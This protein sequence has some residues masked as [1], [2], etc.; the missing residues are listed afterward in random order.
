M[1]ETPNSSSERESAE[2]PVSYA[3]VPLKDRP[4]EERPREKLLSRGSGVLSDAELIA[5]LFGSGTRVD[6]RSLSAV[7]LGQ[8]LLKR[9]GSL[10]KLASRDPR[11]VAKLA[12]GVGPA[13]AAQ[14]SAAFEIGRRV[15]SALP[16]ERV[17]ISSPADAGAAYGPRLRDLPR[18][19]LLVVML[20]TANRVIG[21]FVASTG[22][23]AANLVEPRLVFKRAILEDAASVIC[24]HNHPS[25]NPEPS[26]QDLEITK[27]LVEAGKLVGIPLRDHLI[28]AGKKFTSL[29]DKG[30]IKKNMERGRRNVGN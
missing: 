14:L 9:F 15:E 21:D 12:K 8:G 2:P 20:N 28:I 13:K 3:F 23:L 1:S 4:E 26:R 11:Q 10:A 17:Q 7:E 19:I 30:V 18:E 5:L 25:G 27:Q 22:G 24:L 6:G 29:A 16:E